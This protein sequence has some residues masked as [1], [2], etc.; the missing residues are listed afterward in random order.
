MVNK[1]DRQKSSFC[2]LN[3][4]VL[5][6]QDKD[7]LYF[8]HRYSKSHTSFVWLGPGPAHLLR[9]GAVGT[10]DVATNGTTFAQ[11]FGETIPGM[12]IGL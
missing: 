11:D 7:K 2:G 4:G 6:I 9:N 1:D 3:N 8:L 12:T 5:F 10:I